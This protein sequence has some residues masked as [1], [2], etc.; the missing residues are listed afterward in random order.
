MEAL[1]IAVYEG[2]GLTETSPIVTRQRAR[3]AQAG[4]RRPPAARGAGGDRSRR[5]AAAGCP[6]ARGRSSSTARTSCAATT[7]ATE[8]NREIFTTAATVGRGLRTGDRRAPGRRRVP[9][10]H[11]ADQ[12][13]VQAGQRQIRGAGAAGRAPEAV[14]AD[15]QHRHLR[16]QP[17]V[18]RGPGGAPAGGAA[19]AGP[20]GAGS[21]AASDEALRAHPAIRQAVRAEIDRLAGE[22]KGYERVRDFVLLPEDFTQQ[23]DMLTPS[24]KI[25]RRNVMARWGGELEAL[26]RT[27]SAAAMS[28]MDEGDGLAAVRPVARTCPGATAPP[29]PPGRRAGTSAPPARAAR[30]AGP[31]RPG[32]CR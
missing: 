7:S 15:R 28:T 2:Y 25:K 21:T 20:A 1:G 5:A 9:A 31:P 8:D 13:A 24:L 26:Y 19:G 6:T 23:N 10:H 18:Q 16:G 11:R 22:W 14:A 30:A 17:A 4:Q 12:G 3:A 32:R 27:P 29:P